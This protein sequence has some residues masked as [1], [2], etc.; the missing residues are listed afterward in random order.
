MVARM[1]K[2]GTLLHCWWEYKLVQPLWKSIWQSL[3]KLGINLPQDPA[4]PL[5]G[6]YPKDAPAY[7]KDTPPTMFTLL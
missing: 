5:S 2:K 7:H 6:I 1:W 3:R 4:I